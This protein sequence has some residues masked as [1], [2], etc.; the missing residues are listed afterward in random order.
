MPKREADFYFYY[1]LEERKKLVE[2]YNTTD[3][4]ELIR[5]IKERS[6]QPLESTT[7]PSIKAELEQTKLEIHKAKAQRIKEKESLLLRKLEA[8][9]ELK[10]RELQYYNTFGKPPTPQATQAIKH[11]IENGPKQQPTSTIYDHVTGP[12]KDAGTLYFECKHCEQII[13]DAEWKAR[14][15]LEVVHK[16]KLSS[17]V[18]QN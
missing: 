6:L 9:T 4:K 12:H 18:M 17:G 15:H 8:E 5:I 11:G 1:S 14:Q 13:Y 10:E 2:L 7:L 3:K 16:I